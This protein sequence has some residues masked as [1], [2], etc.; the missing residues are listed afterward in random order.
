GDANLDKTVNT[1]DFNLLAKFFGATGTRWT[2]GDFNF[3]SSTETVDFNLLVSKFSQ[4]LPAPSTGASLPPA[5]TGLPKLI[6]LATLPA[7]ARDIFSDD[8]VR[9]LT[10]PQ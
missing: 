8:L 10:D 7:I 4:S 3:N 2:Q 1:I 5:A 6:E 9:S